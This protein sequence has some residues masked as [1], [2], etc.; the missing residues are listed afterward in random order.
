MHSDGNG[1]VVAQARVQQPVHSG[2]VCEHLHLRQG[3]GT[4]FYVGQ[5]IGQAPIIAETEARLWVRSDRSGLQM[6]LRVVLPRSVD[7]DSGEALVTYIGG[8]LYNETGRWQQLVVKDVPQALERQLRVLRAQYGSQVDGREA[9]ADLVVINGYG[10]PGDTN[11]WIDELEVFGI[12]HGAM[13]GEANESLVAQVLFD[14][15][16]VAAGDPPPAKAPEIKLNGT[17]LLY[18]G[19]PVFPRIVE[20]RG[21]PFTVLR[22]L[23]FNAV[24]LRQTPTAAQLGE[25]AAAGMWLVCPPPV[26]APGQQIGAAYHPV[27]AWHLGEDLAQPQISGVQSSVERLREADGTVKRPVI[28]QPDTEL[29]TYSRLVDVVVTGRNPLGTTQSLADYSTWLRERPRRAR[30]GSTVWSLVA[31][32]PA[33]AADGTMALPASVPTGQIRRLALIALATGARGLFFE[34]HSR[35]DAPDT[36][37]R[38]RSLQ[39]RLLNDELRLIEAW[40]AAGSF[41]TPA[42]TSDPYTT[43]T[44]LQTERA[45][46][47]VP[48][49]LPPNAQHVAPSAPQTP[50][51]ADTTYFVAPGVPASNDAYEL[52]PAHFRPLPHRRVT[53]GVGL[54]LP[55]GQAASLVVL[56]QDALVINQLARRVQQSRQ[57]TSIHIRELVEIELAET[58][59]IAGLLASAGRDVDGAK[60][61]AL[62]DSSRGMLEIA[63]RSLAQQDYQQA[64][65]A[66]RTALAVIADAQNMLW[67]IP[68]QQAVAITQSPLPATLEYLPSMVRFAADAASFQFGPNVLPAGDM[69]DLAALRGAGWRHFNL[70]QDDVR[71]DVELSTLG[72]RAG[73]GSLHLSVLPVDAAQPSRLIEAPPVWVTS[74][75]VPIRAGQLVEVRGSVRVPN[76]IQGSVDGL[77]VIDSVG[78]PAHCLRLGHSVD[79]QEFSFFRRATA[80]GA[81]SVTFALSGIGDAW[82]DDVTLRPVIGSQP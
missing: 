29:R 10:G 4:R 78:G 19:R 21:E 32:E 52:S 42:Q 7:P 3:G 57:S 79:W 51:Q 64:Y 77:L 30:P 54:S 18:Q 49:D 73:R 24:R 34:S 12:L 71:T 14:E 37:T 22:E 11:L 6:L 81:I 17:T 41:V 13:R 58:E 2:G 33:A 75:A 50:G 40:A 23:G 26:V 36:A 59:R 68:S 76:P 53:G 60:V 25:A 46:L 15:P 74:P 1:R 72:P 38:R 20:H 62:L 80:D 35:L 65:R 70:P 55:R 56:T 63:D 61:A 27:L 28:C 5:P 82:I 67:N 66:C 39:L 43:A 44:V 45:R 16:A 48:L 8:T 9:Y 31:T 69:E 47:L